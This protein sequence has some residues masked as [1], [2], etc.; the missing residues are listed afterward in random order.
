V[1]GWVAYHKLSRQ[2]LLT[3]AIALEEQRDRALG[4]LAD[5]WDEG[6]DKGSDWG[7]WAAAPIREEPADQTANPYRSGT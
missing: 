2:Q 6:F 4:K 7:E 5:A 1:S 3:L